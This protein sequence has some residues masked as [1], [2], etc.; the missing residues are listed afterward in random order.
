M[1]LVGVT[2]V[3]QRPDDV[4]DN[5]CEIYRR[6]ADVLAIQRRDGLGAGYNERNIKSVRGLKCVHQILKPMEKWYSPP[7]L[8]TVHLYCIYYIRTH[9]FWSLLMPF[10]VMIFMLVFFGASR[11]SLSYQEY[12]SSL[13][14]LSLLAG[15]DMFCCIVIFQFRRNLIIEATLEREDSG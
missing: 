3:A 5:K 1:H 12:V 9:K 10:Q 2:T 11:N 6:Q 4:F 14:I 8:H 13:S 7:P 15:T